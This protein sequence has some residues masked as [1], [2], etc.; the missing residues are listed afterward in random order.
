MKNNKNVPLEEKE[1]IMNY[2]WWKKIKDQGFEWNCL[3]CGIYITYFTKNHL[4]PYRYT[5][6]IYFIYDTFYKG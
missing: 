6:K 5:I 2:V 4:N 1:E 3:E